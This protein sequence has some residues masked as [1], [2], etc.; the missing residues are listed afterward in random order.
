MNTSEHPVI[1]T[2]VLIAG[3]GPVGLTLAMDLAWRGVKS[4]VLEARQ[5]LPPSPRCN[6]TNAR[7]MEIF[8]RLGCAD[9]IR[10]AGLAADHSTDVVYMTAMNGDE[11]TRFERPTPQDWR[12]GRAQGIGSDWP[13]PEPQHFISQRYMEP[14]LRDHALN[15]Y[16]IDLRQGVE[17]VSFT[18]DDGGVTALTR[19]TATGETAT[20][21]AGFLVGADG[22]NSRVRR[23][24]GARLEGIPK[25]ADNVTVFIRAPRL[26]E[27]YAKHPGWMYRFIGGGVVVAIGG[28]HEW[29]IH[30][31]VPAGQSLAGYDPEPAMFTAV[32]ERFDYQVLDEARW[33]ARAM[34]CNKFRQDRV[35]LAGDA[36]HL[37]IPMGGFGMNAGVGDAAALGW[38]LAGVHQGWLDAKALDA[39]ALERTSLG[40][41]VATQAVKWGQDM[42]RLLRV[43][44]ALADSLRNSAEARADY[45]HEV[46]SANTSEWQAVGM[47]LGFAYLGSPLVAYDDT[48]APPFVL[49]Q[50]QETSSPGVRAPHLW[51]QGQ[52]KL[53]LHD[54]FGKGF[55][56]LRI[57]TAAPS[58]AALLTPPATGAALIAAAQAREIPF[59]V[60]DVPE[61]EAE[62]KYQ[63]YALVLVRPDQHIVW[64]SKAEPNTA[65]AEHVLDRVTGKRMPGTVV[66]H[67]A[68]RAQVGGQ[69]RVDDLAL[70]R[71]TLVLAQ[72]GLRRAMSLDLGQGWHSR[73]LAQLPHRPSSLAYLPDGRL[74]LACGADRTVWVADRDGNASQYADLSGVA[75]GR[76]GAMVADRTGGVFVTDVGQSG[77]VV[78]IDAPS[79]DGQAGPARVVLSGQSG[80][81]GLAITPDGNTLL[82]AQGSDH[83][84]HVLQSRIGADGS[85]SEPRSHIALGGVGTLGGMAIARNG[86]LWLCVPQQR[87]LR[88]YDNAGRPDGQI[89][90]AGASP[91][92]CA[93]NAGA[94]RLYIA[95]S[96]A[97]G[98]VWA[99]LTV[100]AP[101]RA[102]SPAPLST[103]HS[104]NR[105]MTTS[106]FA[107]GPG[108]RIHY[109]V[110]GSGP[111]LI[112]LHGGG[113]GASGMS[114]YSRNVGPLSAH[115]TT[116]VIDFPGWGQSSK[117][118]NSFGAT[119]PFAN[120][121]RAV[122]AFMD[123]A[124]I[125]KASVIGNSF[126]G[127]SA[128]CLAMECPER[129]DRLVTMGPGG[130]W[131]EGVPPTRGIIGLMTY[132]M[133]DGPTREKLATFLQELVYDTS[134]LTPAL[135]DE[136]FAASNNPEITAN[137]PLRLPPGGP[138][139]RQFFITEDPRLKTLPHRSLLIWGQQDKVNLPAGVVPFS[140]VPQQDVVMLSQCGHWAQWEQAD[141]FNELVLWFL[142][143]P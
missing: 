64:R 85:L 82:I 125:D 33:T 112:L 108:W 140:V 73:S 131:L 37:W 71:D 51:R 34:V 6:T 83:A 15:H 76:L 68:T 42:V 139:P 18:Q 102:A 101:P 74:L 141:K 106:Q 124:G 118:L 60:L 53:S 72:A 129:V 98:V 23:D 28:D 70:R 61:P 143:R 66:Q 39:Y 48:P 24:I 54:Q 65:E 136:R 4:I 3:G 138:P 57:G 21:R 78:R 99:D 107:E 123:A 49:D 81:A 91:I 20:I 122:K 121:G 56:L 115:F 109:T 111:A 134:V 132:Y 93:L 45:D 77:G 75:Q 40:E 120:G 1:D 97:A 46:R 52:P 36:A 63:G 19:N 80:L 31:H 11:I 117:N 43:A 127:S 59:T 89:D 5:D 116:Y 17:L 90:L 104:D 135:I 8:R 62:R 44:P 110:Q 67:F 126:G 22:S 96:G 88:C 113:P 41:T 2:P 114:N 50:Y 137:P 16:R 94:T 133:G 87:S 105:T 95:C 142:R 103:P 35:F 100:A 47:M 58:G 32:G 14:P 27:L 10:A 12:Q 30:T 55:T 7:S 86:G 25:I 13:T 26:S 29:L 92:A 79:A 119:G 69:L 128:F 9:A 84:A 130:A 38:L